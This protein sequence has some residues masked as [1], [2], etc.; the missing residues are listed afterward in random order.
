MLSFLDDR[1]KR[2]VL[3]SRVEEMERFE[4]RV[5]SSASPSRVV[6]KGGGE[7]RKDLPHQTGSLFFLVVPFC[8]HL[9][10]G[11]STWNFLC[12][13]YFLQYFLLLPVCLFL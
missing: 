13:Y 12:Q 1:V 8:F 5:L 7:G 2:G 3:S 6:G 4:K 9:D 10:A 11:V